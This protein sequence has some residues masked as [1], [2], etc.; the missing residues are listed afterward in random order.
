MKNA[1]LLAARSA[2]LVLSGLLVGCSHGG[3]TTAVVAT[4]TDPAPT[5]TSL[6]EGLWTGS[7]S[8]GTR[9]KAPCQIL[10]LGSGET[11]M[12]LD[13]AWILQMTLNDGGGA[14]TLVPVG[15]SAPNTATPSYPAT[16]RLTAAQAGVNFAGALLCVG[17]TGT[18]SFDG[19]DARYQQPLTLATLAGT[20]ADSGANSMG[21]PLKLVLGADGT[22][23]G[24]AGT[25]TVSGDFVI[26]NPA[27]G[28]VRLS[29]ILTW[30][31]AEPRTMVAL[32]GAGTTAGKMTLS[33]SAVGG[34]FGFTASLPQI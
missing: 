26:P 1:S 10:V 15:G 19:I 17:Q 9:S 4:A 11:H 14:G 22:V 18:F 23:T 8:D 30:P 3:G 20:Y 6:P 7:Y 28:A 27:H 25:A 2:F 34:S 16:L 32:A 24:Q 12:V 29:L 31:G 21:V 5:V 33:L 13:G